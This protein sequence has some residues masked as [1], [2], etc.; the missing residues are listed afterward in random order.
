MHADFTISK[1]SPSYL[2]KLQ[3]EV[4]TAIQQ[5][6]N[7]MN[8]CLVV[9]DKLEASLRELSRTGDVQACKAARKAAD[10]LLKELSKELKPLLSLL[11]SSPPAVQIMPKV[12][13][14]VSKERELQ[15]KLMLKHST[16]VD[17]YE[18]KS[19]GRDIENRVAAVQ[20]KITLLRQEVDD[21]LEVI[22]EI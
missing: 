6:Q 22:D 10:S 1:S 19:G 18:K 13:E 3:D 15:E 7:I 14:L 17:S 4:Q 21:L 8:R 9:H 12:E 20:Q 5:F 2:A 11:Q 16:V